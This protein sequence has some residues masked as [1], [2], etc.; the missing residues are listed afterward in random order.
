[1]DRSAIDQLVGEAAPYLEDTA[2]N[3]GGRNTRPL[4]I[5][6]LATSYCGTAR[7]GA[8]AAAAA[9][10]ALAGLAT[11]F[12]LEQLTQ[13]DPSTVLAIVCFVLAAGLLAGAVVLGLRLLRSGARLVAALRRWHAV[14]PEV[15]V[16][17]A[18]VF[19][20]TPGIVRLTLAAVS[21][22]LGVGAVVVGVVV[23]GM[24]ILVGA[25]VAGV[26]LLT[27][28]IV[29]AI[30]WWTVRGL[31]R[32]AAPQASQESFAPAPY[33]QPSPPQGY[34][35]QWVPSQPAGQPHQPPSPQQWAPPPAQPPHPGPASAAPAPPPAQPWLPA[36][37]QSGGET[38]QPDA[39]P[40]P[41]IGD[42]RLV[43]DTTMSGR[44][45][46]RQPVAVVLDDGR[47]LTPGVVTLIGRAPV[48]KDT[49]LQLET[50]AVLH[51]TVS[52]TH[53]AFRVTDSAVYVTD[54]SSTNGTTAVD[55]DGARRRLAPWA[56]TPVEI[57]GEVLLG[58]YRVRVVA[59]DESAP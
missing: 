44:S 35:Q 39:E 50:V 3:H 16:R 17:G 38:W 13:P 42:T 45:A 19:T 14:A 26:A 41:D 51:P 4:A 58:S 59:V 15:P 29:A 8:G 5:P 2:P 7:T 55:P 49:D 52:K 23:G 47:R 48:G 57:G 54:R 37:A 33:A 9:L 53:A 31:L 12:G 21:A 56:E 24:S 1:M 32:P 22:F 30:G 27:A 28:G 10:G 20:E 25:A 18:E 46:R 34:G 43:A 11:W 36:G 6:V 40:E